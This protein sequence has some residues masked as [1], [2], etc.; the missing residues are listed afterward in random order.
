[1]QDGHMTLGFILIVRCVRPSVNAVGVWV[2]VQ[3]K[4]FNLAF[5]NRLTLESFLDRN[6]FNMARIDTM[7]I[8]NDLFEF[9]DIGAHRGVFLIRNDNLSN[10]FAVLSRSYKAKAETMA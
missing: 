5:P 2:S 3:V 8:F 10:R 6:G 7:Q 9:F 1:M 4:H